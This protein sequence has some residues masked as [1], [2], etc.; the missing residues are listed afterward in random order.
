MSYIIITPVYNEEKYLSTY[1]D[2]IVKQAL[3]PEKLVMVDDNSTDN[4][5]LIINEYSHKYNW[6]EYLYRKSEDKKIQG[7][8]VIEAFNYGF[9]F[10]KLERVSFISKIDADLELPP[11]YF[12][13]IFKAFSSD[14]KLGLVGGYIKE[15]EN[16]EWV[17]KYDLDYHVRGALKSYKKECFQDING[18]IPV[19]GWDGLDEMK[20]FYKGWKT[21]NLDIGVKHY[22]P[23]ASD[24]SSVSLTYKFGKSNYKNGCNLFL[25]FVRSLVRVKEKPWLINGA[26]F[27][28]GYLSSMIKN[29]KKNV[30]KDLSK[31][32]NNFHRKRI[33]KAFKIR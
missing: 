32:I 24:Y 26:A 30:D 28:M 31:F 8:K 9:N 12:K 15:L 4:S 19:F 13:N 25:A 23:A 16:E 7:S 6:I 17:A 22:R 2:S 1:L 33:Y 27:F 11:N 29:D 21:K 3:L 20:I 10:V 5:S 18:L 14:P